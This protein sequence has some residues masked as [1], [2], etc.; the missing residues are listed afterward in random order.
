[1]H[2][3]NIRRILTDTN[4]VGI[5]RLISDYRNTPFT[6]N[7]GFCEWKGDGFLCIGH[8]HKD[9]IGIMR[10][11]IN[12][13]YWNISSFIINPE[14]RSRGYGNFF[15][16]QYSDKPIYLRVKNDN[17]A[18]IQLYLKNHYKIIDKCDGRYNMKKTLY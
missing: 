15:L 2:F 3:S 7:D 9:I 11:D 14:Y 8:N 10:V 5:T 18:A 16:N 4:S 1:M 12:P 17:E 6:L 13:K